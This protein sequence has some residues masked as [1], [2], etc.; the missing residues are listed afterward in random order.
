[1]TDP[2]EAL[3]LQGREGD[4]EWVQGFRLGVEVGY[5]RAVRE[6][7][8]K[9]AAALRA[10]LEANAAR[11]VRQSLRDAIEQAAKSHPLVGGQA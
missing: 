10:T 4:E 6:M 2:I 11:A 5:G 9:E 1:M 3:A 7:V 8:D